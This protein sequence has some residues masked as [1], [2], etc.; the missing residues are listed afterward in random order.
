MRAKYDIGPWKA[1]DVDSSQDF[2]LFAYGSLIWNPGFEFAEC[3]RAFLRGY[4]RSLCIF[5][6][7]Y[8][9][10]ADF[11]GLVL[12]L[13]RGGS[14]HGMVYRI[15]PEHHE[16]AL[17]AVWEREMGGDAGLYEAKSVQLEIDGRKISAGT[18]I[19]DRKSNYYCPELS[20]DIAADIVLKAC[21]K[22]GSNFEYLHNTVS[23]LQELGIRD[24]LLEDIMER[25]H[26][27]VN[28]TI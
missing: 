3:S 20:S 12:G 19:V 8:R 9:G 17:H 13:D 25:V 23:H 22:R 10:T 28:Y 1:F 2:W 7:E 4:H 21:G 26:T 16:E 18:F 24:R 14:C 11:P 27:M 6:V 5:S 15:A